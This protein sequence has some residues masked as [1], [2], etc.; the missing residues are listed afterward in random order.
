MLVILIHLLVSSQQTFHL[1]PTEHSNVTLWLNLCCFS[2]MCTEDSTARQAQT[3]GMGGL[4]C[5]QTFS[6]ADWTKY[7]YFDSAMLYLSGLT[8]C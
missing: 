8:Q 7:R 5:L 2:L 1:S 3:A 6:S 4:L